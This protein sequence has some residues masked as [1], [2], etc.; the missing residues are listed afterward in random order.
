MFQTLIGSSRGDFD[1]VFFAPLSGF[2]CSTGRCW[3]PAVSCGQTRRGG[4]VQVS[5][6]QSQLTVRVGL[7]VLRQESR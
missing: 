7:R 3:R 1:F 6:D 5:E 2:I 4:Q